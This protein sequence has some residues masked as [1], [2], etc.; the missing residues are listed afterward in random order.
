MEKEIIESK[1]REYYIK[2]LKREPDELGL[3][4]AIGKIRNKKIT[5]DQLKSSILNSSEYK[6]LDQLDKLIHTIKNNY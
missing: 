6:N 5:F 3:K 1:V 2:Y 4:N